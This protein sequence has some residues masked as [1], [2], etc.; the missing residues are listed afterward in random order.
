M[1]DYPDEFYPSELDAAVNRIAGAV[2]EGLSPLEAFD[3][4]CGHLEMVNTYPMGTPTNKLYPE[5]FTICEDPHT[6]EKILAY[7][8][9]WLNDTDRL[10]Q[11]DRPFQQRKVVLF[12]DK[13]IP[14]TLSRYQKAFRRFTRR[15]VTFDIR[16]T[17]D[18]GAVKIPVF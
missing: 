1:R 4:I 8:Y 13:W 6:F 16:L 17:T 11:H 9:K 15:G 3:E 5:L 18:R 2:A 7:I 14:E 10:F 12:T